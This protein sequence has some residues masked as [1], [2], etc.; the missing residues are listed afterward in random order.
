M[1]NVRIF[2]TKSQFKAA[3][4][5]R[6]NRTLKA[7]M[8]RYFTRTGKY[9]WLD[10][11]PSLVQSYNASVHRSIG[12][13][14]VNVTR[15]EVQNELW[16]RQEERGPQKVTVREPVEVFAIGDKVRLSKAKHMLEKGYLPNWTEEIFTVSVA[17][18]TQPTQYKMRDYRNE[19][20]DGSF[21]AAELQK[22]VEPNVHAIEHVI[23]TRRVGGRMQYFVKWLGYG[24][25]HNSWVDNIAD[26][27]A[28]EA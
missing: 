19:L 20:I 5:E 8:W 27:A 11:L 17:L 15:G 6:F 9:E 26:I 2:T 7:R 18:N 12:M 10:I 21:Y 25:E 4:A 22:V 14:P 24:P 16:A 3:I 28:A 23:R 13:A 1:Q